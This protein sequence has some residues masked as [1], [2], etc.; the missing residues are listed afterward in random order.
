MKSW[1]GMLL[2]LAGVGMLVTGPADAEEKTN[3]NPRITAVRNQVQSTGIGTNRAADVGDSLG[4][5]EAVKTG[6]Q[7]LAELKGGGETTVRV[8]ENSRASL[9]PTNRRVKVEEG[10]VLI[11]APAKEGPMKVEAG[12]VTITVEPDESQTREGEKK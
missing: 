11:H 3:G 4:S 1:L 2:G 5:E 6:E 9:D 12:G 7:G 8:G 10:T